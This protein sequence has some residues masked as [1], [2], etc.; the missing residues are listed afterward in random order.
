MVK[1]DEKNY[2]GSNGEVY[3]GILIFQEI[4]VNHQRV[5]FIIGFVIG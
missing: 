3:I 2:Y 4:H 5:L 1:E